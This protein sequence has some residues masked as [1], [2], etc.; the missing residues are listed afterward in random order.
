MHIWSRFPH[1]Y[2]SMEVS[3]AKACLFWLKKQ[4]RLAED[5]LKRTG[6]AHSYS[7][8]DTL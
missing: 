6:A 5:L 8:P 4:V 2:S 3:L 7:A 1:F